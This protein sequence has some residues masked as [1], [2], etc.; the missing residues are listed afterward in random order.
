MYS[1][2]FYS[3]HSLNICTFFFKPLSFASLENLGVNYFPKLSFTPERTIYLTL[4]TKI[5][6]YFCNN[7]FSVDDK[8]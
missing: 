1:I 3:T 6:Q 7:L 5:I 4:Q 8:K 2:G